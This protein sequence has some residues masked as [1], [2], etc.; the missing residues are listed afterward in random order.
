MDSDFGAPDSG[1]GFRV[2]DD[3][4]PLPDFGLCT[5]VYGCH[6]R[7]CSPSAR[8][9]Q[10]PGPVQRRFQ[11]AMMLLVLP[12]CSN[13]LWQSSQDIWCGKHEDMS[14]EPCM[15]KNIMFES[16]F[17]AFC[18]VGAWPDGHF[19]S[20]VLSKRLGAGLTAPELG[21]YGVAQGSRL[22]SGFRAGGLHLT[23][24]GDPG[25]SQ[26]VSGLIARMRGGPLV[27]RP[28]P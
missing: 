7:S 10:A 15:H 21:F 14:F 22:A 27:P 11:V 23:N 9:I 24:E 25:N 28:R 13:L 6:W 3:L 12:S 19:L 8:R 20:C 5:K 2:L 18:F 26:D 16:G 4:N 1:L 17:Q